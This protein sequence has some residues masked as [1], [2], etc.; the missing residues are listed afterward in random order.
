MQNEINKENEEQEIWR[1]IEGYEG[2]YQVSTLGRVK[3]LSRIMTGHAKH[4][5]LLQEHILTNHKV[6]KGYLSVGLCKNGKK[7]QYLLHRIVGKAFVLNPLNL[8]QI[9]H[10]DEVRTNCCADNLEWMTPKQNMNY[11]NRI[12]RRSETV[13]LSGVYSGKNN[14][15]YGRTGVN[16]P[17]FGIR[18]GNHHCAIAVVRIDSDGKRKEYGSL[19]EAAD[20]NNT[21]KTNVWRVCKGTQKTTAGYKFE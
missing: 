13:V 21:T 3:R 4:G 16:S 1:D 19:T 15:M 12:E 18:G 8:P 11:G 2:L 17:M 5:Q 9:N 7:I 10:K 20:D 6:S 14:P